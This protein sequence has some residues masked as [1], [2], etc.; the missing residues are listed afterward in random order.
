MIAIRLSLVILLYVSFFT[1]F[2]YLG[3]LAYLLVN[4]RLQ[5]VEGYYKILGGQ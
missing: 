5:H 2:S 1:E 3:G 4:N